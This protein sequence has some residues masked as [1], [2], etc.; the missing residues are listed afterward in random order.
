MT[1]AAVMV[2][3]RRC[4]CS[5]DDGKRS[6]FEPDG[7]AADHDLELAGLHD[8]PHLVVPE[9]ERLRAEHEGQSAPLP[10]RERHALEAL[11]LLERAR[12]RAHLVAHV[13]L[14]GLVAGARAGVADVD[15]Y[16]HVAALADVI[17]LEARLAD[18]ERRVAQS[19]AERVER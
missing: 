8:A 1:L 9:L 5:I 14:H 13:E 15:G 12:D 10:G 19:V 2:G 6:R 4:P 11:E 17:E 3:I 7:V 16:A 18:L